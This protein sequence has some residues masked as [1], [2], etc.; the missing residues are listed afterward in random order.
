M[1]EANKD[2]ARAYF[3]AV[4]AG[5]LPDS[6]LTPDMTAWT[7]TQGVLDRAT[8]QG[9]IRILAGMC[10][11]PLAFTIQSL[12]AEDDRVVAEATSEGV[13]VNGEPYGN[14]YIFVFRI[15][16][17]RLAAIAEHFNALVVQDKLIPLM[18]Q[19]RDN[20]AKDAPPQGE[21]SRSD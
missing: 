1:S 13:L 17:G 2:L 21:L 8:Y 11:Q 20:A 15:R 6:L 7:T 10:A 5:E 14:T 12:T 16:D 18:Q 3:A 19:L 9:L 4:T